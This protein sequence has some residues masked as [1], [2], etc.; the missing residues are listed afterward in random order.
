MES[1]ITIPWA[2]MKTR[3]A[4]GGQLLYIT[5]D[6]SSNNYEVYSTDFK[7]IFRTS[8][9]GTSPGDS[10]KDFNDNYKTAATSVSSLGEAISTADEC[11]IECNNSIWIYNEITTNS[12]TAD[13]LIASYTVPSGRTFF[14]RSW[15]TCNISASNVDAKPYRLLVDTTK[16]AGA[17][18]SN[19]NWISDLPKEQPI[20]TGGQIIKLTVTPDGSAATTWSGRIVG[21]LK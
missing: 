7:V 9:S 4:K 5:G 20:G 10:G 18:P 13:Q 19:K 16:K 12:T 14:I 1:M 2:A 3:V 15:A 8:V 17:I 21:I 11:S 6:S